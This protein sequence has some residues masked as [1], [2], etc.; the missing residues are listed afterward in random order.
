MRTLTIAT[1]LTA[2]AAAPMARAELTTITVSISAKIM[3]WQPDKYLPYGVDDGLRPG[4]IGRFAGFSMEEGTQIS[5][6]YV[7]GSTSAFSDKA[8][9][10]DPLGDAGSVA[11]D[12][13]GSSGTLFPSTYMDNKAYPVNLMALVGLWADTGLDPV[14]KPFVIGKAWSAAVPEGAKY[15]LFGF[16]DDIFADNRGA[17]RMKITG[18]KAAP[19]GGGGPFVSIVPDVP[20]PATS[21]L[22]LAGALVLLA[23]LFF[24]I[25]CSNQ[26]QPRR[27]K[28]C[29]SWK[30]A[31]S[32]FKPLSTHS[33][34]SAETNRLCTMPTT[35][36]SMVFCGS[37]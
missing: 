23:R 31:T 6:L 26:N 17:I 19:L 11:N 5:F 2:L 10:A 29:P 36:N 24:S 16:N 12:K 28:P 33:C 20:E 37:R 13:K 4:A 15:L 7:D 22:A 25:R 30:A 8:P 21:G 27:N 35:G 3:P 34:G 14:G 1:L 32:S 18:E 9:Y